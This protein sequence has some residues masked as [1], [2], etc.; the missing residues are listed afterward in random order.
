M[1]ASVADLA[2]SADALVTYNGRAFDLPLLEMRYR[3][4]RREP[5][6]AGG[7]ISTCSIRPAGSGARALGERTRATAGTGTPPARCSMRRAARSGRSSGACSASSAS[8]TSRASRSGRYFRFVRSGDPSLLTD[9]F[10]HNRLDL[11]SLAALTAT[12]LRMVALGPEAA[13]RAATA[14]RSA[15]STK[16]PGDSAMP[17]RATG[18]R[19]GSKTGR[20]GRATPTRRSGR[21]RSGGWRGGFVASGA[22]PRRPRSGAACWTSAGERPRSVRGR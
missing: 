13:A 11:L 20:G 10:E 19:P 8:V 5:P 12:A 16:T 1:L 22:T 3:M 14:W 2:S 7:H 17:R 9:V 6:F 15:G 4:H 18:R 21:K